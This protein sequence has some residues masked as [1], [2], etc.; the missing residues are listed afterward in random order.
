MG[1][2]SLSQRWMISRSKPQ[3]SRCS[4]PKRIRTALREKS[5]KPGRGERGEGG[6]WV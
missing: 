5:L 4:E 1:K 2:P 6:G 3:R